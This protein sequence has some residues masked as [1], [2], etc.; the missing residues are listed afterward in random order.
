MQLRY[1]KTTLECIFDN[2][3]GFPNINAMSYLH[4]GS[5]EHYILYTKYSIKYSSIV[6]KN[7]NKY[8]L[9]VKNPKLVRKKSFSQHKCKL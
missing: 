3:K 1:V 6:S 7:P 8:L 2:D 4:T 9:S 5:F